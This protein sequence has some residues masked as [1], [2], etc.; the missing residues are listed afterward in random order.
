M[1]LYLNAGLV[2]V[3]VARAAGAPDYVSILLIAL[4]LMV[5]L[6]LA[7]FA[8]WA[9]LNV[10]RRLLWASR[11]MLMP[12]LIAALCMT[13]GTGQLLRLGAG[14]TV[15]GV[16]VAEAPRHPEAA[17]F[18]ITDGHVRARGAP[19][20]APDRPSSGGAFPHMAVVGELVVSR[21]ALT[22]YWRYATWADNS[23]H[24]IESSRSS[25][26]MLGASAVDAVGARALGRP[27]RHGR[28]VLRSATNPTGAALPGS[29]PAAGAP[30]T[31]AGG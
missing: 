13:M 26:A 22:E 4:P 24:G 20:A 10:P 8:L 6:T 27:S 18:E 29:R 15:T 16:S 2:L 7:P 23:D 28:P 21:P 14:A 25:K 19:G 31:V 5:V 17:A 1:F 9:R 12:Y 3:A 30:I 11:L